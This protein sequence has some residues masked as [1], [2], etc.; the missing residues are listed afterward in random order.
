MAATNKLLKGLDR[1]KPIFGIIGLLV[2]WPA[3]GLGQD[4][5][6]VDPTTDPVRVKAEIQRSASAIPVGMY[7]S[8][9]DTNDPDHSLTRQ[10]FEGACRDH[11]PNASQE[12]IKDTYAAARDAVYGR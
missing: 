10:I 8:L 9:L 1:T 3:G 7:R 4:R 6:A 11:F 5:A 12:C 2:F